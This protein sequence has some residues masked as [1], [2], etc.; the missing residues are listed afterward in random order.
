MQLAHNPT[1]GERLIL[2]NWQWVPLKVA[3][4]PDSGAQVGLVGGEW[5][6]LP[7]VEVTPPPKPASYTEAVKGGDRPIQET[8]DTIGSSVAGGLAGLARGLYGSVTGE[9]YETAKAAQNQLS[10]DLTVAPRSDGG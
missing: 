1:T 3:T 7:G 10:S 8:L 2:E 6:P 4:N 5:R 9:D